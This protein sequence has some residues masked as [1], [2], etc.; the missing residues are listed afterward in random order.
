MRIRRLLLRN[1]RSHQ[2]TVLE[3]D[4]FNFI[5]G[6]NGCGKSSIQMALEYLFTGRCALTDAAGRGA[7][8]LIRS[9]EKELEVSATLETGETICR[10]R[11][12]RAQTIEINGTRVPVDAAETFLTK[13]F[14]SADVLSAVLN[15]DR[16]VEMAEA[17]QQRFLGQLVEAGKIEIPKE[18]YDALRGVNV[19]PPRLAAVGDVEAAH[20]RFYDLRAEASRALKA[21]GHTEKPDAPSDLPTVQEVRSKLE[22]LRQEKERLIAQKAEADAG[23]RNAQARLKQVQAEI[24]EVS[25]GILSPSEEQEFL[26]RESERTH[27]DK[28]RQEL[29]EL[30]AE[31]RAVEKALAI[32]QELKDRCPTCGQSI[33]AAAR[34]KE[35]ERL[36]GRLSDLEGLLQAAQEELTELGDLEAATSRL[37]A[38]RD[39]VAR[40]AKLLEEQSKV[41]A[42]QEPDPIDHESR[43]TILAERINKGE[44]VLEK[45]QQYQSA[46][47]HWE[48]HVKEKS[49]LE[50]RVNVLD[51]LVEFLGPHGAMMAQACGRI[52]SFAESLNTHLAAFGYACNFTLDPFEIRLISSPGADPGFCLRQLSES[53]RFRFSIAIQLAVASATE[54]RFVVIDRA[55]LLDKEKRKL[56]T[57]LLSSSAID[58]AIVLATGE[59]SAPPQ[60]PEGVKFMSLTEQKPSEQLLPSTVN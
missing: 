40:R 1:F 24:E 10:R 56:L 18:I 7:E 53:E 13:H 25:A 2:E 4:R 43:M 54:I 30:T 20:K 52:G 49:G 12:T 19:D 38:H 58:Q 45:T 46:G 11:R 26:K 55:D 14:G 37:Q 15:A 23:W 51:R 60:V 34:A 48:A 36:R 42:L 44:Q 59:E 28:L 21:L 29:A 8:A 50:T 39:A 41:Q 57:A 27:V 5:R 16:F 35:I 31:Q 33:P 47:E 3:L 6:P 9:G 17:E 32:A 22:D